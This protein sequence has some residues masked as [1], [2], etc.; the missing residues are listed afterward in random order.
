M[1]VVSFEA[2]CL[3]GHFYEFIVIGCFDNVDVD[4]WCDYDTNE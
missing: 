4:A 2:A 3:S 1:V